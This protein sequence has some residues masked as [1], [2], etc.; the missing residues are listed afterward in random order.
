MGLTLLILSLAHER[1]WERLPASPYF[2][3]AW[4][5]LLSLA[6]IFA[7]ALIAFAMV[8]AEFALIANTSALTF[9]VAGTFKEIV[10]G[11]CRWVLVG[12]GGCL[13]VLGASGC[14]WVV[15]WMLVGAGCLWVGGLIAP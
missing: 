12:A 13:W 2:A 4:M 6:I 15:C 5:V 14:L 11:G 7:G 3:N 9:M 1:L 10:T 8:V